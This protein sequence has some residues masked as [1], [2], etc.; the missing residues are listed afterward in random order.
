[1]RKVIHEIR[2]QPL[3]IRKAFVWTFAMF[4]FI[5][6]GG[7]Y[8]NSTQKKVVAML[9]GE[10]VVSSSSE[11]ANKQESPFSLIKNTVGSLKA[12]IGDLWTNKSES[13]SSK[14]QNNAELVPLQQNTLP[15]SR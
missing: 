10:A 5:I 4:T 14:F 6:I 11:F 1:M 13:S 8:A 12:T 15:L 2:Q 3:H 9:N 7:F